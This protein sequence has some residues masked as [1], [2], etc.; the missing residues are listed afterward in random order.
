M[1]R[2]AKDLVPSPRLKSHEEGKVPS[3]SYPSILFLCFA[4]LHF[5]FSLF[6]S[7]AHQHFLNFFEFHLEMQMDKRHHMIFLYLQEKIVQTNTL[8]QSVLI[9]ILLK[10]L[11]F[12]TWLFFL[13]G[14]KPFALV[15][16]LE[17]F[18]CKFPR[19][20]T[21]CWMATTSTMHFNAT[22]ASESFLKLTWFEY[23]S[24]DSPTRFVRC[25]RDQEVDYAL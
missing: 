13:G 18:F 1:C 20:R 14:P 8:S 19:A 7:S 25:P 5:F 6:E 12:F 4:S 3:F 2:S 9:S 16:A 23:V 22:A 10:T 15:L 21:F 11:H 24:L 17:F